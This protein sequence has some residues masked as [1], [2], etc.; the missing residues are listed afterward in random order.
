MIETGSPVRLAASRERVRLALQAQQPASAAAAAD[1]G[2]PA[3]A[4]ADAVIDALRGWWTRH[5]L[6][7]VSM[8]A[9][10][11]AMFVWS[12]PWRWLLSPLLIAGLLPRLITKAVAQVSA[13]VWIAM[14]SALFKP[15]PKAR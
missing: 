9:L 6:A 13:P 4:A 7:L 15:A 3:A 11:G 12:R 10:A 8:A 2:A 1:G 5:P 14:L